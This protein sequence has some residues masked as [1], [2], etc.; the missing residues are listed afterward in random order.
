MTIGR[1]VLVLLLATGLGN[2]PLLSQRRQRTTPRPTTTPAHPG[3][4]TGT[5]TPLSPRAALGFEPGE[6]RKLADWPALLRYYEALAKNS[7]RVRF[8]ELGKSTL[9]APFIALVVSSPQ[10][11][12]RLDT[13][14]RLN[15]RLADPRTLRSTGE[16]VEALRDGKAVV[17][18]TSGVHSTEV[19]GSLMPV[20]LAQRLATDTSAATRTI[21]DNVI[22]LLVP[23]L[24]PD[25]VSIVTRWYDR[26]LG[27]P[28]E[29]TRPPEL[30]RKPE[31]RWDQNNVIERHPEVADHLELTLRRFVEAVGRDAIDA[32]PQLREVARFAPE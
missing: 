13:Y 25:G 5:A 30:Y 31:D 19:G 22:V 23:S 12:R 2:S 15:A 14:R 8:R 18:I 7:D 24:N 4:A 29:G 20:L 28:A 17:L 26:T 9:G 3:R 27:T 1:A 11:L 10:N 32:L 16:T 6:D 21:L